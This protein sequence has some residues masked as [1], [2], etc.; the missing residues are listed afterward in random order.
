MSP[1]SHSGETSPP[2]PAA[3]TV[4]EITDPTAVREGVEVLDQDVVQLEAE[5]LR[6]RR[7]IVRLDDTWLVYHSTNRNVRTRTRV[8]DAFVSFTAIGPTAQ[9][10]VDGSEM[11]VDRLLV[12]APGAEV[13]FVVKAGYESATVMVSPPELERHLRD[14]GR[15]DELHML[16]GFEMRR[17]PAGLA[18]ALFSLGRRLASAAASQPTAFDDNQRLRGQATA[19]LLETLLDALESDEPV[20]DSR[21]ERTRRTYSRITRVTQDW[22]LAHVGEPLHVT[23]LCRVTGVS[24]RT[25]QHAFHEILGLSPMAYLTRLRLHRVR[26]SLRTPPTPSTRVSDVALHWGFWHFGDFSRAYKECFGERPS[27]TLRGKSR[28]AEA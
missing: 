28:G 26:N 20:E 15:E 12:A 21:R 2:T 24:Q 6:V 9:G 22:A 13:E 16:R 3:V 18:R 10:T 17:P 1:S 5:P 4:F 19:E 23:D 14:R 27:D 7:V 11:A 25:L 8:T